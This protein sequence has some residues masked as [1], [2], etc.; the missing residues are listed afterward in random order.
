M[1]ADATDAVEAKEGVV[2]TLVDVATKAEE[3]DATVN[4]TTDANTMRIHPP[5][6]HLLQNVGTVGKLD[7]CPRTAPSQREINDAAETEPTLIPQAKP[8]TTPTTR[9]VN[10]VAGS[11]LHQ[12]QTGV[13]TVTPSYDGPAVLHKSGRRIRPQTD[14]QAS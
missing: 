10:P 3:K 6:G 4:A 11:T 5:T 14:L 2:E 12:V 13:G 8:T 7:I 9:Q 1:E